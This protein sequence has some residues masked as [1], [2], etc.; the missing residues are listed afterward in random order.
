MNAK[1]E[2][3]DTVGIGSVLKK[4]ADKSAE[5]IGDELNKSINKFTQSDI[6]HDD[7]TFIIAKVK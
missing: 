3:F 4:H 1:G 2:E 7:I 5:E 6:P